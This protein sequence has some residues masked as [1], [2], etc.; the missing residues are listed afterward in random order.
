MLKLRSAWVLISNVITYFNVNI[1]LR[2]R[3]ISKPNKD[4]N[5]IK[6]DFETRVVVLKLHV[7]CCKHDNR[8]IPII[9]LI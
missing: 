9:E 5:A 4:K 8:S 1:T 6:R 2:D 7:H 3:N